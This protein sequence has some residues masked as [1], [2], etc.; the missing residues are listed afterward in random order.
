ML[1]H[2]EALQSLLVPSLWDQEAHSEHLRPVDV[3][4]QPVEFGVMH[5]QRDGQLMPLVGEEVDQLER[6]R[7]K[8]LHTRE[9]KKVRGDVS[10]ST[11]GKKFFPR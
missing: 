6:R 10:S 5:A 11:H 3:D 2:E 9:N 8:I 7:M 1:Q 4:F